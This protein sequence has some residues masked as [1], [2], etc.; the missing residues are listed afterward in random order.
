MGEQERA[1]VRLLAGGAPKAPL[2]CAP[3][4]RPQRAPGEMSC[5][6]ASSA[7]D[8]WR[9]QELM[10]RK[11]FSPAGRRARSRCS[12]APDLEQEAAA[13]AA[14]QRRA[15]KVA[16][17]AAGRRPNGGRNLARPRGASGSCRAKEKGMTARAKTWASK[18]AQQVGDKN[19]RTK[20]SASFMWIDLAPASLSL[21]LSL[22]AAPLA[23]THHFFTLSLSWP[24]RPGR[25]QTGRG[26]VGAKSARGSSSSKRPSRSNGQARARSLAHQEQISCCGPRALG[27]LSTFGPA[28]RQLLG[29]LELAVW[30]SPGAA[31]PFA[32][33]RA[34][35]PSLSH[36]I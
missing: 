4:A 35:W 23:R 10:R 6:L 29:Q 31:G 19:A 16:E 1:F 25:Q 28:S 3:R 21:S 18:W 33:R 24:P 20:T 14:T 36:D 27:A 32:L 15:S 11:F 5:P 12:A 13:A 8:F 26:R 2:L 22:S 7:R 17:L 34:R 30:L 9:R